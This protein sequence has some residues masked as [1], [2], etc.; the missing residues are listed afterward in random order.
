[1]KNI[2]LH[3]IITICLVFSAQIIFAQAASEKDSHKFERPLEGALSQVS[4]LD[5]QVIM[6]KEQDVP[7]KS[8][9]EFEVEEFEKVF[10]SM[11]STEL[12]VVKTWGAGKN[13]KKKTVV[14]KHIDYAS[15]VPVLVAAMQ[16]QQILILKQQQQID[17][18]EKL[19]GKTK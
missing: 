9:Y 4:K 13:S 17:T 14:N 15:L 7:I 3:L 5:P 10:P 2:T 16:E 6:S 12:K 8:W 11:V 18:L 1:M 19:I